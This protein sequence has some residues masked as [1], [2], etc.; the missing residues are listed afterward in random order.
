MSLNINRL[1]IFFRNVSIHDFIVR[2]LDGRYDNKKQIGGVNFITN[3]K[4]EDYKSVSKN[5]VVVATP[6][7][8]ETNIKMVTKEEVLSKSDY[9]SI[10]T[11]GNS[12][13]VGDKELALMKPTA[14][15]IN[16]SRGQL[17]VE[18][19]LYPGPRTGIF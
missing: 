1:R 10:H 19:D 13:I 11:G 9:I 7:A 12:I 15:L 4:I 3:T 8:F 14:Y 17:I 16:T 6:L 5:G 2:P 18:Q